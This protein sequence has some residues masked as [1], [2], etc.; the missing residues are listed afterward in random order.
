MKNITISDLTA[1]QKEA[2]NDLSAFIDAPITSDINSRVAVLIGKAGTGKTTLIRLILDD[3]LA[4][5]REHDRDTNFSEGAGNS[6]RNSIFTGSFGFSNPNVF[7]V[8]L[9]HKAKNVLS[10][11]IHFVNTFASYFGL[12]E[13]YEPSGKLSFVVDDWKQSK[14]NCKLPHQVA[15]HDEC[16]MYDEEM[17]NTVITSTRKGVKIIFMGE[18]LPM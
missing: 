5:D 17:M 2:F 9:A 4:K 12:K 11:S 7:G 13:F 6:K 18:R 3:L 8:T 16:S 15:V 1:S 10:N 14:S